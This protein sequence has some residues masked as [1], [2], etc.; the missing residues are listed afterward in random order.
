MKPHG[1]D[2]WACDFLPTVTLFFKTLYA[3]AIM[4]VE[5]RRVVHI[6]VTDHPTDAWVAQQL[7]EATPFGETPKHLNCD[8]DTKYGPEF[9]RVAETCW[10]DVIHTP[11]Q[12]PTG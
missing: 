8:N 5:S 10:M 9:G 4:H 6:N 3:F 11:Y 7:R 12:A 2:V 1:Q